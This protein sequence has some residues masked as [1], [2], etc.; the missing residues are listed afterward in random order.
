MAGG[1][2]RPYP[3]AKLLAA[4]AEAPPG[5]EVWLYEGTLERFTGTAASVGGTQYAYFQRIAWPEGTAWESVREFGL[6]M[7]E[8]LSIN[9]H[10]LVGLRAR[11]ETAPSNK[12]RLILPP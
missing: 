10:L 2:G 3:E 12:G 7:V 11:R 5:C 4:E 9:G 1:A 8:R 6:W